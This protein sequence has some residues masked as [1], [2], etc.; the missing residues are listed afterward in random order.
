ME[1]G[2][3][4][5]LG[6]TFTAAAVNVDGSLTA[7]LLGSPGAGMLGSP[8]AEMPTLVYLAED[9]EP[10]VGEAAERRGDTDPMRLAR[11]FKRR[12]GEPVPVDLDETPPAAHEV[13]ALLLRQ[14]AATAAEGRDGPPS[15]VVLTH[16]AN[17]GW[18]KRDRL[19]EAARLAGLPQV[20]LCSEPEAAALSYAATNRVEVGETILVYDLGGG[21]FDAAVLLRTPDGFEVLGEPQ[22]VERLGGADFDDGV[23]GLVRSTLGDRLAGLDQDDP[24]VLEGLARLR[25]QCV[26]AKE[27]LSF[28]TRAE[29]EV[30]LPELHT[31]VSIRR[32]SL[33]AMIGPAIHETVA[34]VRRALDSASVPADRLHCVVLAGGSSRIPLVHQMVSSA[35]GRPVTLLDQ[36][37]TA[38]ALGAAQLSGA[39]EP[40]PAEEPFPNGPL[41]RATVVG[42]ASIPGREPDVER[43]P[44]SRRAPTPR[45][46]P[47]WSVEPT[48][49]HPQLPPSG[50]STSVVDIPVPAPVGAARRSYRW[51]VIGGIAAVLLTVTA[52]TAATAWPW[53]RGRTGGSPSSLG[54]Q[55]SASASV[56]ASGSAAGTEAGVLWKVATGTPAT[57]PPAVSA[58][59]IIVG[60][61][62][63]TLRAFGR[64]D[65]KLDWQVALGAGLRVSTQVAGNVV[66]ATTGD[67]GVAGIDANA[68]AVLWRRNLGAPIGARPATSA[69]LTYVAGRDGA[70]EAYRI[71]EGNRR[72]RLRTKGEITRP[73]LVIAGTV[74]VA[75]GDGKLY[76]VTSTGVTRWSTPVGKVVDGPLAAG[77]AACAVI[78][79]GTVKCVR[80]SDGAKRGGITQPVPIERIAG[81]RL[82]VYTAGADGS[83]AGWNPDTAKVLW[84]YPRT[85]KAGFPAQGT[86]EVDVAYPDG[87][88][89]GLDARSGEELWRNATGDR[90][91]VGPSSDATGVF[92]VG[93]KGTLYALR[94]PG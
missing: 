34:A 74:V 65:G 69:Q 26:A 38:I 2:L 29:I 48:A 46:H 13:A 45:P 22:G 30:A 40:A 60:G 76:G 8:G 85:G 7:V 94:P 24:A 50:S 72:W 87:T 43:P 62:D 89:A 42:R 32:H 53:D 56:A 88:L 67:G 49:P 23:L 77:D 33:E 52:V 83:I 68:G 28:D 51:P 63:G 31:R 4:I 61:Q 82:L 54:S 41:P 20:T 37:E 9:G 5:D 17:W 92:A 44:P 35:L 66:I 39:A 84:R 27:A 15:R 71:G 11:E 19:L 64:A 58:Q 57:G 93:T 25:R 6:T 1:Y 80:A 81:G 91:G 47:A 21:T 79:N 75:A 86:S 78:D 14:V 36:P 90:F 18:Y 59:R 70:V 3:G 10:L 16:P 73:P 55:P 12:I